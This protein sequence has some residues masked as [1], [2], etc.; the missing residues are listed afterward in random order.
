MNS[1]IQGQ[2]NFGGNMNMGM[3]TGMNQNFQKNKKTPP[4]P[5]NFKIVKCL[6]YENSKLI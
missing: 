6:N 1:Q 3:D 2:G 4:N 5:E